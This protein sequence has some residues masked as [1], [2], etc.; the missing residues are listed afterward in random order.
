MRSILHSRLTILLLGLLLGMTVV[1]GI[2]AAQDDNTIHACASN[3]TGRLRLV[4]SPDDCRRLETPVAWSIT[5]P[6]GAQGE[7]GPQGPPGELALGGLTCGV[8]ETV[9]GFDDGG[10]P[11]CES[12]AA[13]LVSGVDT[14]GDG[15]TD[16][17]EIFSIDPGPLDPFDADTD[18]DG[19]TDFEEVRTYGTDPVDADTDDDG[20]TD[21]E[22]VR[23]YGTDPLVWDTDGDTFSD[24]DEVAAGTDPLDEFSIPGCALVPGADLRGCPLAGL[25]LSDYVLTEVDVSGNDLTSTLF[26]RSLLDGS[27]FVGAVVDDT[28]FVDASLS[29]ADMSGI[30]NVMEWP[31]T[32]FT[33]ADLTNATFLDARLMWPRFD[34][35]VVVGA[36][37]TGN[38]FVGARFPR[39]DFRDVIAIADI[40]AHGSNFDGAVFSGMDLAGLRL[41]GWDGNTDFSS[42]RDAIFDSANLAGAST[43]TGRGGT[44]LTGASFRFAN[45]TGAIFLEAFAAGGATDADFTGATLVDAQASCFFGFARSDF[46]D[47][48]L[49]GMV[50]GINLS[51]GD[52]GSIFAN[53]VWSNT[54]CPDGT[55]SDDHGSTCEGHLLTP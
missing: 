25:D 49:E 45:L 40:I 26:D 19:L 7:T 32:Y 30:H 6:Q 36:D 11:V 38:Q 24:G 23:T 51:G 21:F 12:L 28:S 31:P 17:Q 53:A 43:C 13:L 35:A 2:A 3:I 44:D 20:L 18:D 37:F 54:T 48:N 1:A 22:E 33:R 27:L 50:V 46:T 47:A 34:D 14:D 41:C 55:N 42:F 29:G 10:L 39:V 4:T 5:G 16:F 9:I 15:L 52:C 8:G